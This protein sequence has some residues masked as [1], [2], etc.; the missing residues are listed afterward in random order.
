LSWRDKENKRLSEWAL[1]NISVHLLLE[2]DVG[3][4]P[5]NPVF[6]RP[7]FRLLGHRTGYKFYYESSSTPSIAKKLF[8]LR[9]DEL[10]KYGVFS[11]MKGS[12]D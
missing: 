8:A 5:A 10:D 11:S 1:K 9:S 6:I 2:I 4:R 7:Y 3:G 12:F